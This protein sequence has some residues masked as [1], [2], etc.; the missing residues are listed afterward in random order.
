MPQVDHK[1]L[2]RGRSCRCPR[3]WSCPA[4][5]SYGLGTGHVSGLKAHRVLAPVIHVK[6]STILRRSPPLVNTGISPASHW[7][8]QS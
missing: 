3:E 6:A 4:R 8:S 2:W 7:L 5:E 1:Q